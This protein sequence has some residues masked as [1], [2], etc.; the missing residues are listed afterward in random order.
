MEGGRY[1]GFTQI[2]ILKKYIDTI[3][4]TKPLIPKE[5]LNHCRSIDLGGKLKLT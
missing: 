4:T 5:G 1:V 3:E 2:L